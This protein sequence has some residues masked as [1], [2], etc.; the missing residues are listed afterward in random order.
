M[1]MRKNKGT[2]RRFKYKSGS[3]WNAWT[4]SDPFF[5][6]FPHARKRR[7]VQSRQSPPFSLLSLFFPCFANSIGIRA[8]IS[9]T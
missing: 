1:K 7:Y 4:K 9:E 8:S 2:Q 3:L 6:F 5:F